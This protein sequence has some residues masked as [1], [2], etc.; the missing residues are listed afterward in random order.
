M[1]FNLHELV[2]ALKGLTI[3]SN[4]LEEILNAVITN[5]LPEEF[6][7]YSYPSMKPLSSYLVDMLWRIRFF[8]NWIENGK[9][10][11]FNISAFFFAQGYLTSILQ[12]YA[13]K[14]TTAI[15]TISFNFKICGTII[16][17]EKYVSNGSK[18]GQGIVLQGDAE[19][20]P[21]SLTDGSYITGL[22]IEGARFNLDTGIIEE[23]RPR[24]LYSKMPIIQL[25]PV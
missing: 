18:L 1:D 2:R 23:A 5:R 20:Q 15:D 13:R 22:Y 17:D 6:A 9:P 19:F 8:D 3:I 21:D 7:K 24:E 25:V 4:E 16:D 11:I 14:Y 12:N 10:T